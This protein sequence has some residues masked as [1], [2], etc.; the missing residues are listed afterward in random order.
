MLGLLFLIFGVVFLLQDLG[1]WAFWNIGWWTVGLFLIGTGMMC[2][3][4]CPDCMK[5]CE[6]DAKKRKK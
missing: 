2:A 1:I 5:C 4:G 3:S 6:T